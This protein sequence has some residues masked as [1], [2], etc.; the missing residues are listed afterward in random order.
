[1]RKNIIISITRL[2]HCY[3]STYDASYVYKLNRA[4]EQQFHNCSSCV[5]NCNDQSCLHIF[6]CS[7]SIWYFIYSLVFFTVY[8]YITNSQSEQL[9]DG[10]IKFHLLKQCPNCDDQSCF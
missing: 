8:G 10:L 9:P 6:T 1:M 5:D 4:N 2:C 3:D 7:S